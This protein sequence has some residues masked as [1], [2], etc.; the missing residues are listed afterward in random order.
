MT[1][2]LGKHLT[3][4]NKFLNSFYTKKDSDGNKQKFNFIKMPN[5][6][7][8]KGGG[9]Y[10]IPDNKIKEFFIL[11]SRAVIAQKKKSGNSLQILE[12]NNFITPIKID[13]DFQYK[14]EGAVLNRKILKKHIYTFCLKLIETID[15]YL[16][17]EYVRT[18][19]SEMFA[20]LESVSPP[21]VDGSTPPPYPFDPRTILVFQR[22]HPY[23][24]GDYIKDGIHI[25]IPELL[26]STY[27]QHIIRGHIILL[28]E[29]CV[30]EVILNQNNNEFNILAE[31][32]N[33][34]IN[35]PIDIYD[36]AVISRNAWML[37]GS[38]KKPQ[39]PYK[40]THILKIGNYH[41]DYKIVNIDRKKYI[42]KL[43][44]K[45]ESE[46]PDE[47]KEV[48]EI[49]SM[50]AH[51]RM[52]D[53]S[54]V[55]RPIGY[56]EEK[57]QEKYTYQKMVKRSLLPKEPQ[58][59]NNNIIISKCSTN[60]EEY[61]VNLFNCLSPERASNYNSW[62]RI[63]RALANIVNDKLLIQFR[64]AFI[65][66]SRTSKDYDNVPDQELINCWNH[67]LRTRKTTGKQLGLNSIEEA[68]MEDNKE[69]YCELKEE[70]I[71]NKIVSKADISDVSIANLVAHLNSNSLTHKWIDR[72]LW[73]KFVN[74]VWVQ[75]R[76]YNPLD[77]FASTKVYPMMLKYIRKTYQD[78]YAIGD[79]NDDED[80][81]KTAE[82]KRNKNLKKIAALNSNSKI[83]AVSN[84]L[85]RLD[86]IRCPEFEEN[87]D[88]NLDIIGLG[89][90]YV[91][92]LIN[93]Q[94]RKALP[95]DY[96]S[97][98][99]N[100]PFHPNGDDSEEYS[101]QHPDVIEFLEFIT[102]IFPS[103]TDNT[104]GVVRYVLKWLAS[105]YDGHTSDELFHCLV[106]NG[107]NGK[108]LLQDAIEHA[109]GEY[110]GT[111]N[112]TLLTGKRGSAD[113][114]TSSYESI[115]NKRSI[116]TQEPEKAE[117][118][119][120][121]VVKEITGGDTLYSRGLFKEGGTFK[122]QAKWAIVTNYMPEVD[123]ED[124]ALWRRMRV[125]RF[126]MKFVP[127]PDPSNPNEKL[128]DDELKHKAKRGDWSGAIQWYLL[129]VYYPIYKKEGLLEKNQIPAEIESETTAYRSA[130]DEIVDFISN[131]LVYIDENDPTVAS[132]YIELDTK[133]LTS[134]FSKFIE[135]KRPRSAYYKFAFN[136]AKIIKLFSK[137]KKFGNPIALNNNDELLGWT[138]WGLKT[139][140]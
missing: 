106:G 140:M 86:D 70:H 4:F 48:L 126:P 3:S 36:E 53:H 46:F 121:G 115:R 59:I 93:A 107:S 139:D 137:R 95:S 120:C 8:G 20:N 109:L 129:T 82:N 39:N 56:L 29:K 57:F 97:K 54:L 118:L 61:I 79:E 123:A 83:S 35:K 50:A 10:A 113:G 78:E 128:R 1:N 116:W 100:V 5:K 52:S 91:Y 42:K 72:G 28:L 62:W 22:N 74:G 65:Q 30:K 101:M 69:L 13:L 45:N 9:S 96:L 51:L 17:K 40:I 80:A 127:N 81:M 27:C 138:N 130:N 31:L 16:D 132:T 64:N 76:N 75:I 2:E 32:V 34:N 94:A 134:T 122:P 41:G 7:L 6:K 108:S 37:Y 133:Y 89:N 135:R 66:W 110:Y 73:R 125:I 99:T 105:M 71:K 33:D 63:G 21:L 77:M 131:Q 102:S 104:G 25:I 12:R 117:K 15:L 23:K 85:C 67:W 98:S 11:Y 55:N 49:I 87:L 58:D 43:C 19:T 18:W 88:Q 44:I 136:E 112:V 92:D 111:V 103:P 26:V 47:S 24:S 60:D 119:N 68:A 90:G 14:S 84:V 38:D 124:E 114:C